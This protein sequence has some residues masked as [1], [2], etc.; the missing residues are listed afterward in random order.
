MENEIKGN[1]PKITE[2]KQV[3]DNY[4]NKLKILEEQVIEF[5]S[6]A[7]RIGAAPHEEDKGKPEMTKPDDTVLG[8]FMEGN[9]Q[10]QVHIDGLGDI[11]TRISQIV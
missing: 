7:Q 4:S 1:D 11:I 5:Q 6:I 8:K 2:L 3:Q 10:L 9:S